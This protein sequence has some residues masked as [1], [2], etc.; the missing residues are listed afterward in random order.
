MC[1]LTLT[2]TSSVVIVIAAAAMAAG[3]AS[4]GSLGIALPDA[5]DAE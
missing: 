2:R 4:S 5:A 3:C 1:P